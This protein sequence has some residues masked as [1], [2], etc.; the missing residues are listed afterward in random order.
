MVSPTVESTDANLPVADAD[1]ER[2]AE[3]RRK[4]RRWLLTGLT[5][6]V[7]AAA[8]GLIMW[9]A[10]NNGAQEGL[11]AVPDVVGKTV[12]QATTE[13][14]DAGFEVALDDPVPDDRIPE[15]SVVSTDPAAGDE[16]DAGETVTI[17]PSAGVQTVA[18]PEVAGR[19]EA[20]AR[21]LL[22]GQGFTV[23]VVNE[24]SEDVDAGVVIRSEPAAGTQVARGSEVT[25]L[26][27]AGPAPVTVPDVINQDRADAAARLAR[28]GFEV[29][30][31]SEPSDQV[32]VDRVIRTDP[33][34]GTEAA[35][36]STVTVVV[37]SGPATVAVPD[38]IGL[39]QNDAINTLDDRGL[40]VTVRDTPTTDQGNDGRV[41]SQDPSPGTRA[42]P[43]SAVTIVV[44]RFQAPTTT[45]PTTQPTPTTAASATTTTG[46]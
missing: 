24:Q 10:S 9:L 31:Q 14:E 38:V 40:T 42:R 44:G 37:A 33:A 16:I 7:I 17:T 4:R 43:G 35:P 25:L 2:A 13:L 36:G 41:L 12:A 27:S 11:V 5:L 20:E 26:V 28:V 32:A 8:F 18:V 15:G 46:P 22:E 1:F 3:K 6:L 21:G 19:V 23:E 34:P 45:T 39:R 30:F 29:D